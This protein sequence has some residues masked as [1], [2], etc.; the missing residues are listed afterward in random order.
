MISCPARLNIPI[1]DYV[2]IYLWSQSTHNQ[3]SGNK[4]DSPLRSSQS[5]GESIS[6]HGSRLRP[7]K[8]K[9]KPAGVPTCRD[10]MKVVPVLAAALPSQAGVR[11]D[12]CTMY[13]KREQLE[14]EKKG[15]Q[16][17]PNGHA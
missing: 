6:A 15:A 16:R 14:D 4:I 17:Q 13:T 7:Y 8:C 5:K 3:H 9:G 12:K 1:Y 2:V 10:G 11:L